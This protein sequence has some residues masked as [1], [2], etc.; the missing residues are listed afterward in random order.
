M[1][2]AAA[3]FVAVAAGIVWE[4]RHDAGVAFLSARGPAEWILYPVPSETT[5]HAMV[6]LDSFFR[7]SFSLATPVVRARLRVRA[8]RRFEL[9][10]NGHVVATSAPG[11]SWKAT[12]EFDVAGWLQTGANQLEVRV[13]NE[14]GPPALWLDLEL[15]TG[16]LA[17]DR[18]W[19][20]S[21]AGATWRPAALASA[22]MQGHRFDPDGLVR[23]PGEALAARWPTLLGLAMLA[24]AVVVAAGF[25]RRRWPSLLPPART[26]YGV[27]LLAALLWTALFLNNHR[28]LDP[29]AGFDARHHLAYV[30]YILDHGA[31]PSADQGWQTY[32]P[33]LYYLLAS[34]LLKLVGATTQDASGVLA[35]RLLGLLCGVCNLFLVAA[36]LRRL[37]PQN[38]RR[39]VLGTLLAAFLPCQLYLYQFPTNEMLLVTLASTTLLAAL[40]LLDQDD[41]PLSRYLLLG[42]CVGLAL[43]AKVSALLL[44]LALLATLAVHAA[45]RPRPLLPRSLAKLGTAVLAALLICGWYYL[46]LWANFGS[47]LASNWDNTLGMDWWQDPGYHTW[48]D[49]ARFGRALVAPMFAGFAGLADGLYSTLWGEALAS[50]SPNIGAA[51]AWPH[52]RMSMAYLVALVPTAALLAGGFAN[53]VAWLRRPNLVGTLLATLSALVVAGIVSVSLRAPTYAHAKAFHG[54]IALVPLCVCVAVGLDLPALRRRCSAPLVHTAIVTWA[55]LAFAALWIDAESPHA[56]TARGMRAAAAGEPTAAAAQLAHAAAQAPH[57]WLPRLALAELLIGQQASP[58]VV[59]PWLELADGRLDLA[60]RHFLLA[61]VLR[62]HGRPD[63]ALN[64]ARQGIALD[65]DSPVLYAIAADVLAAQGDRE[66]AV[67]AWREALRLSPHSRTAHASLAGLLD[68]LGQGEEA[69]WQW[70]YAARLP[71]GR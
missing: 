58:E 61:S 41:P 65:P 46:R 18:R 22:P 27:A 32:Q 14:N 37:F 60:S 68:Q 4:A 71:D 16:P 64:Q 54:M 31:L 44:A 43:L 5:A 8:F 12:S 63:E 69:A 21:G 50:G 35:L 42:A 55:L 19:D 36:C 53:L 56:M 70:G 2:L 49:Y 57:D 67:R 47:P 39:Q 20:A 7:R 51:P 15:P 6:E 10:L 13:G 29:V 66:G 26:A 40:W 48:H 1:W 3:A 9:K 24:A 11:Q 62:R 34:G 59:Q 52:D 30:E 45:T 28:S 17:T 25:L 38:E 23:A 33:P